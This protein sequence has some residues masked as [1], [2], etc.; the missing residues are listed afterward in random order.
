MELSILALTD[1]FCSFSLSIY[2]LQ[3]EAELKL[4]E[5][6]TL[7]RVEEAIQKK[8]EE[9]LN[10]EE[11]KLGIEKQLEVGRRRLLDEVAAQLDKEKEVALI[12]AKQKEVNCQTPPLSLSKL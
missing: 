5:E 12:E 2:R 4:I 3:Q 7:R 11:I 10:S 8:V 1:A 6:E 9:S